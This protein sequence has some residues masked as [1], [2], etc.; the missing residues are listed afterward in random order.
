MKKRL[1]VAAIVLVM[2][3]IPI[4]ASLFGIHIG[5]G[6]DGETVFDPS[7]YGQ[8]LLTVS[9]LIKDYEELKAM[10]DLQVWSLKTIPVDMI[11]RYRTIGAS[12]YGLQ[13]PFDRFGNLG[14]WLQVVN[15]GGGGL[16]AYGSASMALQSYGALASKL[17]QD[18]QKQVA[19][20]YATTELADGSNVQSIETVGMLRGNA[21]AVD[22]AIRNLEMDSLSLDPAMNTEVGVLNKINSAAIASLRSTRDTNRLLL[23]TVEEQV[24][25]GKR[26]RDADVSGINAAIGRLQFGA[27]AKAEHTTGIG[28]SIHSFR[29]Q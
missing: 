4:W 1:V 13:L 12:W 14:P 5:G 2:T 16:S 27:D 24:V 22:Q 15:Q 18:E 7:V 3:S 10:Y 28:E 21:S 19:A 9:Q 25:E 20:G 17:A 8:A 6:G 23:S 11:S 29:W 26:K